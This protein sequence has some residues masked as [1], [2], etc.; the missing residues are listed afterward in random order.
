MKKLLVGAAASLLLFAACKKPQPSQDYS[1]AQ[2]RFA[3]VYGQKLD[4]AYL[5]PQMDAI[6]AQLSR[7]PKDSM[8]AQA[9]QELTQRIT[10]GRARMA[11]EQQERDANAQKA[12]APIVMPPSTSDTAQAQK[13]TPPPVQQVVDAGPNVAMA[14]RPGMS[15]AEFDKAFGQC[16]EYGPTVYLE[17]AGSGPSDSRTLRDLPSCKDRLPGYENKVVLFQN[18]AVYTVLDKSSLQTVNVRPD[19][20]IVHTDAGR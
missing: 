12:L 6:L 9:A 19:G 16:F 18:A 2:T 15:A 13:Q 17:G 3:S 5:D 11:K 14:P 20:G 7:V 4:A 1:E 10:D 8:D